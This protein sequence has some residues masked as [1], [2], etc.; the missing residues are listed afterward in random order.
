MFWIACVGLHVLDCMFWIACVGLLLILD[1]Y[2]VD[3]LNI[4][5]C[6][7]LLDKLC[8]VSVCLLLIACSQYHFNSSP[9][10]HKIISIL[11]FT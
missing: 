7:T 1:C 8:C 10:L 3:V 5:A 11:H 6:I 4:F 2:T 9:H